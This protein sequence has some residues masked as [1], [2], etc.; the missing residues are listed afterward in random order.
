M[1]ILGQSYLAIASLAVGAASLLAGVG[2]KLSKQTG[3]TSLAPGF[4]LGNGPNV[5]IDCPAADKFT[6]KLAKIVE[7]LR[8]AAI[9]NEWAVDWSVLDG[10]CEQA[11]RAASAREHRDSIKSYGLAIHAMIT[12]LPRRGVA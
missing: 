2:W 3:G 6:D 9:E 7:E 5:S 10:H 11:V 4:R 1:F 12:E 8:E